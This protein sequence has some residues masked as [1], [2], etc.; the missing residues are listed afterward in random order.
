[1]CGPRWSVAAAQYYD[2]S[3]VCGTAKEN[4]EESFEESHRG[5]F[6]VIHRVNEMSE[7]SAGRLE[8][9]TLGRNQPPHW[10]VGEAHSCWSF[11]QPFG[12]TDIV[13]VL[14]FNTAVVSQ[15][16]STSKFLP[17]LVYGGLIHRDFLLFNSQRTD[18][19]W[20]VAVVQLVNDP[21]SAVGFVYTA[22]SP[23]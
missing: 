5:T 17:C 7:A 20:T 11:L 15:R 9:C 18:T 10:F 23:C 6:L 4:G 16:K 13:L 12:S 14:H 3:G 8:G 1:M 21:P 2:S 22:L 19:N